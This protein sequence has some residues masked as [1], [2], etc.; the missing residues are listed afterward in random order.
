MIEMIL[1]QGWNI[2][3][4]DFISSKYTCR[5]VLSTYPGSKGDCETAQ[6]VRIGHE[7]KIFKLYAHNDGS[8]ILATRGHLTSTEKSQ[9]GLDNLRY[10]FSFSEF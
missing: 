3:G 1:F 10:F 2:H 6:F 7:F 8:V 5:C 4:R 9:H